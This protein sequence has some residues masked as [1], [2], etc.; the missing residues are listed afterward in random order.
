MRRKLANYIFIL[1]ILFQIMP[2]G[3]I[4]QNIYWEKT[5][6]PLIKSVKFEREGADF[7][8][9]I[10][11][12]GSSEKL[13]LRFDDLVEE[14]KR[15]NYEVIHCNSDWT[16]SDLEPYEYIE[17]FEMGYIENYS[18]SINTIQRYVHY[19]QEF[20]NSMMNFKLSGNY[21]IK[22]YLDDNPD[23][24]VMVR[25]F[26]VVEEKA[27]V[28]ANVFIARNPGDM[29]T[30]QEI[31]V[32]ISPKSSMSFADPSRYIKVF[33]QQNGRRDWVELSHRQISG[34][35]IEYSFKEEN[36]FE[37]GNEF[38]NF[39]FSSLRS[40]TRNVSNLDFVS[41]EHHVRLMPDKLRSTLPYMSHSDIDGNYYIRSERAY[42]ADL[43]S[44][45]AWVNFY[46]P[47]PIDL[48]GSF[49]VWGELSDWYFTEQN[50]M[51]YDSKTSTYYAQLYLKQGFY[52]YMY[53]YN[54]N[55]TYEYTSTRVEGSFSETINAY[56]VYV[57]YREPGN[58]YD[59]L[60]GYIRK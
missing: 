6:S 36:V 54:P 48:E 4:S 23:N 41:G 30:K 12:L 7:T 55:G 53:M 52:D 28:G 33:V 25:R 26:M 19:W 49:Y 56:N 18:N 14:T 13:M 3:L 37:G 32:K 42:D 10:I 60:I 15:Y 57:Y 47:M 34:T 51:S 2:F 50:K 20:P 45:Y 29:R 38:R 44:D 9:P 21:I 43:E 17:G 8:L 16:K 5:Y 27:N 40:R 39:D 35:R 24:V 31:D 11:A 58:R 59:S 22:V 1:L 46:L